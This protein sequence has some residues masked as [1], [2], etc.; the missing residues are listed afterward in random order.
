MIQTAATGD[1]LLCGRLEAEL[2]QPP[3]ARYQVDCH[4]LPMT[5]CCLPNV[6]H[7]SHPPQNSHAYTVHVCNLAG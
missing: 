2:L 6:L 5:D 1:H 4:V 3:L 7:P